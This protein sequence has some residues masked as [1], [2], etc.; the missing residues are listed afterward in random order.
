[1]LYPDEAS[2]KQCFLGEMTYFV[3]KANFIDLECI[4]E[5]NLIYDEYCDDTTLTITNNHFRSFSG[6]PSLGVPL[7]DWEFSFLLELT[8][9]NTPLYGYH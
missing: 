4:Y 1:M 8:D 7:N 5:G 2:L 9:L 6:K 3:D